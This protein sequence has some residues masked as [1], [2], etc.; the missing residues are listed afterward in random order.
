MYQS[1]G[2]LSKIRNAD[3]ASVAYY[4]IIFFRVEENEAITPR[5][6][7][8]QTPVSRGPFGA[9]LRVADTAGARGNSLRSDSPRAFIRPHRRCSA[10]DNGDEN[11]NPSRRITKRTI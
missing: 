9:A 8:L 2:T 11:Q 5:R 10:Q 6:D 3:T 7:R 1:T 4:L